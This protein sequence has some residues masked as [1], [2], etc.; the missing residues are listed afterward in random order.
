MGGRGSSS[1]TS[2]MVDKKPETAI[3]NGSQEV[4]KTQIEEELEKVTNEYK[5]ALNNKEILNSELSSIMRNQYIMYF[6]QMKRTE[7]RLSED[8]QK[9]LAR[10]MAYN[11]SIKTRVNERYIKESQRVQKLYRN[12][13]ELQIKSG[14]IY[15]SPLLDIETQILY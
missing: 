13:L 12:M 5:K 14:H 9:K 7:D 4:K 11:F 1:A 10:E 8:E 3:E 15:K 6:E 2:R